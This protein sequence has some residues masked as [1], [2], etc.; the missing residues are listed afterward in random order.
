MVQLIHGE[1]PVQQQ[2]RAGSVHVRTLLIDKRVY[3][4]TDT[5]DHIALL[6][7][8]SL[9]LNH[10]CPVTD[11]VNLLQPKETLGPSFKH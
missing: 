10:S 11:D 3:M 9:A 2:W 4:H 5:H 6:R 7:A 1:R 8:V